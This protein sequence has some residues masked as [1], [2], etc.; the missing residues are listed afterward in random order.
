MIAS[1][2]LLLDRLGDDGLDVAAQ[3]GA[4]RTER[5]GLV[6]LNDPDRIVHR[7]FFQ[8]VGQR[9]AEQL[10]QEHAERIHVA[11]RV[12]LI[13]PATGLLGAHVRERADD[14]SSF[15]VAG[16]EI[17]VRVGG[18]CHTEVDDLGLAVC[19]HQHVARLE[20]AMNDALQMPVVN[21]ATDA[22]E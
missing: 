14:L 13:H 12:Q 11:A 21:G 4:D 9:S 2:R 22:G 16:R 17:H 6:L 8:R 5:G 3:R 18:P 10:E 7:T 19:I 15:R 20:I 1:L